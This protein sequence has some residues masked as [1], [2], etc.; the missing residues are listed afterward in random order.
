MHGVQHYST[1]IFRRGPSEGCCDF[2]GAEIR[3]FCILRD[4]D[5][6]GRDLGIQVLQNV[7]LLPFIYLAGTVY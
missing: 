6:V 1:L 2:A 7:P 3:N 4:D 5:L